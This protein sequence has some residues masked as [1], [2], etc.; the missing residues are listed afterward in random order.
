MECLGGLLS[1]LKE[2]RVIEKINKNSKYQIYN[3]NDRNRFM[4]LDS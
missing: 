3:L 4:I 2:L 1:Y